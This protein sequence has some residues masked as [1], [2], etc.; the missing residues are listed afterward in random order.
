MEQRICQYISQQYDEN[1]A[2]SQSLLLAF[3][4]KIC[5]AFNVG[6]NMRI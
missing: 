6:T 5:K 4:I 2:H 3:S 1:A